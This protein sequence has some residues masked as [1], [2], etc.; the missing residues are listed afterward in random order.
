MGKNS[1]MILKATIFFNQNYLKNLIVLSNDV[2]IGESDVSFLILKKIVMITYPPLI[3][4]SVHFS[5]F[6]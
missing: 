6:F 1:K 2:I 4:D 5:T 3:L